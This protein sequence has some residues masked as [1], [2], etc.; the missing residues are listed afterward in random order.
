MGI[1]LE[2]PEWLWALALLPIWALVY[3]VGF[4]PSLLR[5]PVNEAQHGEKY[6]PIRFLRFVVPMLIGLAFALLVVALCSPFRV[7]SL[8]MPAKPARDIQILLDVSRS[9]QTAD[10]KPT[11]LE[12]CKRFAANFIQARAS[13][14]I[15]LVLFAEEA[16]AYVPLTQDHNYL[17]SQLQAVQN[18]S[19]PDEGT[20]LGSAIGVALNHLPQGASESQA[21]ILLTDGAGNRGQLD[22]R[23]VA[24]TAG[25]RGVPIHSICVGN[26]ATAT[27]QEAANRPDAA[28][29]QAIAANS[30]GTFSWYEDSQT[31]EQALASIQQLNTT[32]TYTT[33]SVLTSEP[34]QQP[35]LWAAMLCLFLAAALR[36]VGLSN[37]LEG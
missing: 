21:I 36:Y 31:L 9:M 29:L 7:R 22:P 18:G 34:Y 13:D 6:W 27:R 1:N 5:M 19:L 4:G 16:Y 33:N 30:H 28:I 10:L 25:T 32:E 26:K 12:A 23:L 37:P 35:L 2:H 3:L 20:S 15:G 24:E 8:P 11:R 14:R 17:L